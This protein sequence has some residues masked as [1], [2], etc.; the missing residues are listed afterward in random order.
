MAYYML[1]CYG[2]DAEEEAAALGS[3]P[4]FEGVNWMLGRPVTKEIPTPIIIEL[5]P[6]NPGLMMPMFY[7]GVLLFSDEMI[8]ILHKIGVTNFQCFDTIIRD[9][10]KEIDH[11]NYKLI[12]IIG[13]VA[14]ADF[15]K[16]D[17]DTHG[18]T[19]LIDTDF[20]SLSIDENKINGQ[21]LF[22]LAESVNGIVI[23]EDVK[24]ALEEHGIENLDFVLPED[25]IG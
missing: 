21:R 22:R 2:M 8:A 14:A 11:T 7:S 15:E 19:A 16:S 12:N 23:H 4:K 25:W 6:D 9:T 10:V 20:D 3:W 17:Y 13:L 5:D 24:K 18:G 1:E